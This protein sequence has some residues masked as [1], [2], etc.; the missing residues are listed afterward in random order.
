MDT[1]IER[2][3]RSLNRIPNINQ[4][5]CGVAALVLYR[6]L[7]AQG[8]KPEI[9]F[10]YDKENSCTCDIC[11]TIGDSSVHNRSIITGDLKAQPV[12]PNHCTIKL[13]EV[14]FPIDSSGSYLMGLSDKTHT[15]PETFLIKAINHGQGW[16]KDFDR[17]YII[18]IEQ[19]TGIDLSDIRPR[20]RWLYKLKW[21]AN[22]FFTKLS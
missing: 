16:N 5:G 13:P 8:A 2:V 22:T 20:P 10:H 19:E 15:V 11:R 6:W 3:M 9:L 12:A 1:S 4:G 14:I 18:R 7:K 21:L 17:S